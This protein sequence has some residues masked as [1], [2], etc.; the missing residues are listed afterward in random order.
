MD[1]QDAL[2]LIEEI[3]AMS[4]MTLPEQKHIWK[5]AQEVATLG[6]AIEV[7]C[8]LGGTTILLALAGIETYAV[9]NG[10]A[11]R[12]F[13]FYQN[14]EKANVPVELIQED[15]V[16]A[17][18]RFET[19]SCG[20]VIIDADHTGEHP[21]NDICAWTSKVAPGGYLMI[22]DVAAQIPDVTMATFRFL[23]ENHDY[24]YADCFEHPTWV[25]QIKL[26][27]LHKK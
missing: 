21:Y 27:S 11:G 19:R 15:A 2:S 25:G 10:Q 23:C 16:E 8:H 22:D 26:L 12:I 9:D 7:G 17:A 5:I 20:L 1:F 3:G 24:G 6:P 13:E 4:I 14:I 18:K